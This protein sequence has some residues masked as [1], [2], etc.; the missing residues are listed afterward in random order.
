MPRATPTPAFGAVGAVAPRARRTITSARSG[1]PGLVHDS[2]ILE[3]VRVPTVNPVTLPGGVV[4][5]GGGGGGV[6]GSDGGGVW[7]GGGVT[8]GGVTVGGG[9]ATGAGGNTTV[10]VT[11][12]PGL[13]FTVP[14]LTDAP[15]ADTLYAPGA[16]LNDFDDCAV[17]RKP[18]PVT[19]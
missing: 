11:F 1:S 16:T 10:T 7:I 13:T 14:R 5:A 4:S 3:V 18:F 19:V 9:V 8:V 2:A 6:V 15:A 17:L 12:L